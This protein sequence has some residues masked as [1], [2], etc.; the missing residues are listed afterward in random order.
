MV[1]TLIGV[2]MYSLVNCLE[3]GSLLSRKCFTY[4]I[5]IL[6]LPGLWDILFEVVAALYHAEGSVKKQWLIDAVEI[7]CVSSFPSTVLVQY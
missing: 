1:I 2:A 3:L 6:I 7:S 5:S 4:Q